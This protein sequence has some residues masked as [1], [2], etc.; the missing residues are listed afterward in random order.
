MNKRNISHPGNGFELNGLVNINQG[1]TDSDTLQDA[2]LKLNGISTNDIGKVGNPIRLNNNANLPAELLPAYLLTT[3]IRGPKVV[4]VS[5]VTTFFIT[6]YASDKTYLITPIGG[7]VVLNTTTDPGVITYTAPTTSGMSGFIINDRR[8]ELTV[9]VN[10][11]NTIVQPS[12]LAPVT[13]TVNTGPTVTIYSSQFEVNFGNGTHNQTDW[14][15]ATNPN[16]TPGTIVASS[17]NSL[18]NLTSFSTSLT[19]N[20]GYWVRAKY[21]ALG[22]IDSIW[23]QVVKFTTKDYYLPINEQQLINITNAGRLSVSINDTGDCAIIGDPSDTVHGIN[24][25]AVK[26]FDKINGVWLQSFIITAADSGPDDMFGTSVAMSANGNTIVVSSPYA[27][28]RTGSVYV[29]IRTGNT[30]S[31]QSKLIFSSAFTGNYFGW[32]VDISTN[33]D[34]IAIG[35]P[36]LKHSVTNA[37]NIGAV[38]IYKRLAGNWQEQSILLPSQVMNNS[39]NY[40]AGQSVAITSDGSKV[41]F[42]SAGETNGSTGSV[43]AAYIYNY[44]GNSWTLEQRLTPSVNEAVL[45]GGFGNAVDI[46]NTG[47]IVF[48][49]AAG[50]SFLPNA[51]AL[52]PGV[53]YEYSKIS[54]VWSNVSKIQASDGNMSNGFGA[55]IDCS[56]DGNTLTV[57]SSLQNTNTLSQS[58]QVY[59]HTRTG[60][61]W[62][63]RY[64]LTASDKKSNDQFGSS[65]NISGDGSVAIMSS[66]KGKAYIFA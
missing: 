35:C 8:I 3:G 37:L 6:D 58:G 34:T 44:N 26:V 10:G 40:S 42:G 53:V 63:E 2:L 49:G 62:T 36:G 5:S 33:G 54:N 21:K 14:E 13:G 48:I 65:L 45:N 25:G 66:K 31:Q 29:F 17:Y 22:Y 32:S 27:N 24:A 50:M 9:I 61:S 39:V 11:I 47:T 30:W 55:S 41:I 46:N 57:G 64:R 1:G 56:L 60:T 16:F 7:S 51:T 18:S 19:A 15:I 59:I 38:I 12:I 43:G 28:N 4:T 23:S 20:M 52:R